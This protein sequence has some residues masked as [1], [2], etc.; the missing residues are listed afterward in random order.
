MIKVTHVTPRPGYKLE[1]RFSDGV[2]GEVDLS[3]VVGKGVFA[4]FLD[5]SY[6]EQVSV[7]PAGEVVWSG[8]LELCPDAL[9]L[10][11]TGKD[12]AD[13][14]PALRKQGVGRDA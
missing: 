11:V 14:F 5:E 6:F 3:P 1:L 2:E 9:Y 12:A 10:R 8:E 7:G 4:R 13:F